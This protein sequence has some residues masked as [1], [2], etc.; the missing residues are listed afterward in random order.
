MFKP[1][2]NGSSVNVQG[3]EC[4]LPPVGYIKD[5]RTGSLKN[6]GVYKRNPKNFKECY[7]EVD[8]RFSL[9][10]EWKKKED[11][12]GRKNDELEKFIEECWMYRLGGFWFYNNDVPTYI[13][14]AHWFYLSVFNIDIGLPSYRDVDRE[15]FYVWAYCVEDPESYGLTYMTKRRNGKTFQACCV[16]VELV[17][18]IPMF[19]VGIQSKTENDARSLFRKA[20]SAPYRQLPYFFV[21]KVSKSGA[22]GK[23]S[24]K[25]LRFVSGKNDDVDDELGGTMDY[26]SND[27]G[28]YDGYKLGYYFADEVAKQQDCD[29]ME[30]WTTVKRCLTDYTGEIIGKTIHTTT[31]EDMEGRWGKTYKVMWDSSNQLER[32]KNGR[33]KTGMYRFMVTGD[34]VRH[35][36]KYGFPDT[37]KGK[38]DIEAERD[39]VR[40]NPR[41]LAKTIRQDFLNEREAFLMNSDTCVFN[42]V[43]LAQREQE[44]DPAWNTSEIYKKGRFEWENEEWGDVK[45]VENPNGEV[46]IMEEPTEELRNRHGFRGEYRIPAN[47]HIYAMGVD[48]YEFT[49][50]ETKENKKDLSDGAFAIIKKPSE[51]YPSKFDNGLVCYFRKRLPTPEMFYTQAIMAMIYFGTDALIERNRPGLLAYMKRFGMQHYATLLPNQIQMGIHATLESNNNIFELTDQYIND[52]ISKINV[53]DLIDDWK[54]FTP[55]DTTAYDGAMAFGYALMQWDRRKPK[56]K[57][58]QNSKPKEVTDYFSMFSRITGEKKII[59]PRNP[60]YWEL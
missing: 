16:G 18:R 20:V 19:N 2:K 45:F 32:Q 50:I 13:T 56:V 29:I 27:E 24:D 28:A 5:W 26:R 15:F 41:V 31:V 30:R 43:L 49:I 23:V 11:S 54:G 40:D 51:I 38:E 34:R 48:P 47:S 25:E 4:Q 17:T 6:I 21:P 57:T 33:T 14:G 39:A 55:S 60:Y 7:W 53:V 42:A 8:K 36:D 3:L 52:H 44:I 37:L 58:N 10:K 12:T 9:Y 35:L 59:D 1:I 22:T 46:Y